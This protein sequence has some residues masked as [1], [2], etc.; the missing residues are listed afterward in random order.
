MTQRVHR[1]IRMERTWV[2]AWVFWLWHRGGDHEAEKLRIGFRNFEPL[3]SHSHQFR[4][5]R[6]NKFTSGT[7]VYD[8]T[9]MDTYTI[10]SNG[11]VNDGLR[12]CGDLHCFADEVRGD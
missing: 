10:T 12:E 11:C 2:P 3:C 4:M 1:A 6:R 5:R 9:S 8:Q 7:T